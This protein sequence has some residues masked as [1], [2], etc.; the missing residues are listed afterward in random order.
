MCVEQIASSVERG[1]EGVVNDLIIDLFLHGKYS[2]VLKL[3][4]L[5]FKEDGPQLGTLQ[6]RRILQSMFSF[7]QNYRSAHPR[8]TLRRTEMLMGTFDTWI[9]ARSKNPKPLDQYDV[10]V[11]LQGLSSLLWRRSK[12]KALPRAVR[13]QIV[14]TIAAIST[15]VRHPI[16]KAVLAEVYLDDRDVA[17][18]QS[19]HPHQDQPL[20]Q[21]RVF[22]DLMVD[23]GET[24][25][26]F[27][28]DGRPSSPLMKTRVAK[29]LSRDASKLGSIT[30]ATLY[31]Q[32]MLD[33]RQRLIGEVRIAK[34]E[35]HKMKKKRSV[36]EIQLRFNSTLIRLCS[37]YLWRQQ[38]SN[39]F[40]L[41]PFTLHLHSPTT[42]FRIWKRVIGVAIQKGHWDGPIGLRSVVEH[43][44]KSIPGKWTVP[45]VG[46]RIFSS[47]EVIENTIRIALG[48]SLP[49]PRSLSRHKCRRKVMTRV[50]QKDVAR[51]Q[52]WKN[53]I[54]PFI[55]SLEFPWRDVLFLG[56]NDPPPPLLPPSQRQQTDN[57]VTSTGYDIRE[58]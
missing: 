27:S 33:W 11:L 16:S 48:C 8:Q 19:S 32:S 58:K 36:G 28:T 39:L 54:L 17:E 40:H 15:Y 49:T 13:N 57:K 25:P 14:G 45:E 12:E 55:E 3:G 2:T 34:R 53:T 10:A 23:I 44:K 47:P 18:R 30:N 4:S 37:R 43:L 9:R 51:F 50:I 1:L 38:L 29:I 22:R 24:Y 56:Y 42:F 35:Y 46:R 20:L 41:L 7:H 52:D 26:P 6:F 5:A 31:L 21:T